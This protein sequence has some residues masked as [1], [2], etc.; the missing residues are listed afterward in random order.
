MQTF[1]KDN[2]THLCDVL[3]KKDKHLQA[4][5]KEHGYP[6][7]W[8]RPNIFQTLVLTILEQQVSLAAA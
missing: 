5:I 6:P 7:M 1:H 4:I 2:F 3:S 8:T